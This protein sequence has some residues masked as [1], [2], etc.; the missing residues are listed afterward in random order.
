MNN[1]EKNFERPIDDGINKNTYNLLFGD[2]NNLSKEKQGDY[3]KLIAWVTI[4]HFTKEQ[5]KNILKKWLKILFKD[6]KIDLNKI[7]FNKETKEYEY[8]D[9]DL[10]ITFNKISEFIKN[11]DLIKELTSDKRYG[12][13][14]DRSIAFSQSVKDSKIVTGYI[15]LGKNRILHSVIEYER[16]GKTWILDWTRNLKTT[17][18][19]YIELTSFVELSSISASDVLDDAKFVKKLDIGIKPF[20]VF[21]DELIKDMKRNPH[22][23]G[24]TEEDIENIKKSK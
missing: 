21:R 9:K 19:K 2:D 17:K 6:K 4:D 15:I 18:E 14:H 7:V 5:E 23:F 3:D 24:V 1:Q 8:R 20:V 10:V 22:I 12:T 16:N 13:C 11:E